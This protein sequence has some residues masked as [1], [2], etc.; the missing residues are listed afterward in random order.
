MFTRG[1]RVSDSKAVCVLGMHRSGTSAVAGVLN[2]LGVYLGGDLYAPHAGVNEKGY[3][4]HSDIVDLHDLMLLALDSSWDDILPLPERWWN[5]PIIAPFY[6]KL[7]HYVYRDFSNISI[8]GLKD[9]RMCRLLP[10]WFSIFKEAGVE[11]VFIIVIRNPIGVAKSLEKRDHFTIEK[12]LSL[13]L[14]HI[15]TAEHETRHYRRAFINYDELL[16]NP[17]VILTQLEDALQL[18]WPNPVT[19][20][21]PAI[22]DFL[23]P[24]LRHHIETSIPRE[25]NLEK[26]VYTTYQTCCTAA[27]SEDTEPGRLFEPLQND[28]NAYIT[29]FDSLLLSHLVGVSQQRARLQ[30]EINKIYESLSWKLTKPV[31]FIQRLLKLTT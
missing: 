27:Q 31:R 11:P 14:L 29:S 8:W 26:L 12:S 15:L 22:K 28:F 20:I 13:W 5:D 1:S 7:L 10:L 16:L 9:P 2:L 19:P 30:V 3:W 6:V 24:Q 21:M 17:E 25:T 23:S 18:S 4:E